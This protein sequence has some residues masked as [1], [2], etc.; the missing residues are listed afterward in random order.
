M[1]SFRPLTGTLL[2]KMFYTLFNRRYTTCFRPLTGTLLSK[3]SPTNKEM[4]QGIVSVPSRGLSYLKSSDEIRQAFESVSVPSR[5]L[6]Y[7]KKSLEKQVADGKN[8]F[9]P[10]TGTLLSKNKLH[11]SANK[12]YKSFRPLTGTLLS[13]RTPY[14]LCSTL[15]SECFRPLTGTL[16][17]KKNIS[18]RRN[19]RKKV[20]VPSRGNAY[21][22]SHTHK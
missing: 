2:S 7:L 15:K 11:L 16:L 22:K 5:G 17:S 21:L 14:N 9:R 13:K 19:R 4:R 18:Y 10:L 3:N 6:S 1:K 12:Y 20:S 8:R